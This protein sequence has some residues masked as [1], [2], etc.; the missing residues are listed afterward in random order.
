[1]VHRR[2]HGGNNTFN[3]CQGLYTSDI[4]WPFQIITEIDM[5]T[6]RPI[7]K[8]WKGGTNNR[9]VL[10]PRLKMAQFKVR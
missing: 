9:P 7:N 3:R 8:F 2:P 1:M 6:D 10:S 5:Y 4:P